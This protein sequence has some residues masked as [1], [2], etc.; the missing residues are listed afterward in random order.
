MVDVLYDYQLAVALA[1]ESSEGNNAEIEMSYIQAVFRKHHITE[2]EYNLSIAHYSRDPKQ[3]ISITEQVSK[4]LAE[5]LEGESKT[6]YA[7]QDNEMSTDTMLVWDHRRGLILSAANSNRQEFD[8]P[9]RKKI[10][11]V[12]GKNAVRILFG[13]KSDWIYREGQKNGGIVMKVTF[14]NDSTTVKT[15]TIR[16][17]GNSQ[18]LSVVVPNGRSVKAVKIHLYQSALWQ[19]YPQILSLRDLTLWAINTSFASTQTTKND[20][21]ALE[22]DGD[23]TKNESV[24]TKGDSAAASSDDNAATTPHGTVNEDNHRPVPGGG[25]LVN[26][27]LRN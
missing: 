9:I 4:R 21:D 22:G 7:R 18:G 13:F 26:P 6:D 23:A 8:I 1:N 10:A 19:R 25:E 11:S 15:E 5:E 24:A 20:D 16:E 12:T 27:K 14:D 3:M 2:D 17:Y